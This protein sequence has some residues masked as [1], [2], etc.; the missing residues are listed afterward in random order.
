MRSALGRLRLTSVQALW[1]HFPELGSRPRP[2]PEAIDAMLK[3]IPSIVPLAAAEKMASLK[4]SRLV[5][6]WCHWLGERRSRLPW[7][8]G[9]R[10]YTRPELRHVATDILGLQLPEKMSHHALVS[11][12]LAV[13]SIDHRLKLKLL[14]A[15]P[16]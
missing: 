13:V 12:I 14:R 7:V 9:L 10:S 3:R 15:S 16:R 2:Q 6:E 8:G 5:I 4:G 1:A 11:R